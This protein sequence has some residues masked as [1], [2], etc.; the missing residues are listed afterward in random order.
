MFSR[1]LLSC[2]ILLA[3][4]SCSNEGITNSNSEINTKIEPIAS[5]VITSHALE[6]TTN[7][8]NELNSDSLESFANR[9]SNVRVLGLGEQTHGA[10]SVFKLKVDLIKYLHEKHDFDLF[11][12]ESGLYDVEK[13]YQQAKE[14]KRI[15]SIAPGN[16]FYMYAN[17]DEVTPLFDYINEQAKTHNPLKLVGFDSQHTGDLSKKGLVED[18]T[19]A[20]KVTNETK[21]QSDEW[22]KLSKQIQQVLNG[23]SERFIVKEEQLFFEQLDSLAVTFSKANKGFWFRITKGLIAQAKRQWGI[24]DNRSAEMGANVKWWAEQF[25]DKK[26]IVWAH[27]WHLTKEGDQQVNAGQVISQ[28]FKDKYYMVHFTGEQGTFLNYIDMNKQKVASYEKNSIEWLTS[29]NLSSPIN[30]IDVTS[31][32]L[33]TNEFKVFANDYQQTLLS[34]EWNKYFDGIFVLKEITPLSYSPQIKD[35]K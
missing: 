16:I 22:L 26:I 33:L 11:I 31:L 17:S 7:E 35:N 13:I 6:F 5:K 1:K 8:K 19:L 18:L 30:F 20:L 29:K 2:S 9:I 25:P 32:T 15:K 27:T 28:H 12:L 23:L 24:E 34:E 10:G 21:S 4:F 3:L 14:G